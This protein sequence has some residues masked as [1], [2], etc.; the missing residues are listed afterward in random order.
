MGN[1]ADSVRRL[2][3]TRNSLI[4][5]DIFAIEHLS[6][7]KEVKKFYKKYLAKIK[8]DLQKENSEN[9][10]NEGVRLLNEG[11]SLDRVVEYLAKDHLNFSLGHMFN[12]RRINLWY[13]SLPILK[14]NLI[15][16]RHNI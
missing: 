13:F 2:G 11:Y 16:S 6:N 5:N 3:D 7:K 8:E 9:K 15:I 1:L 12:N 4:E 14:K 10:D